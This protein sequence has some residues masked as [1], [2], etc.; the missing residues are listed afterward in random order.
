MAFSPGKRAF[1]SMIADG[2]AKDFEETLEARGYLRDLPEQERCAKR[3][4]FAVFYA[5]GLFDA[6]ADLLDGSATAESM[7]SALD[8]VIG[9]IDF[10][11]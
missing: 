11:D 10:P 9:M 5:H 3:H 8:S 2:V 6:V 4:A 7:Q 1:T